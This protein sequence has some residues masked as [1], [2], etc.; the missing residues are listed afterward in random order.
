MVNP[1]KRCSVHAVDYS[2]RSRDIEIVQNQDVHQT[3]T[4]L[5][6]EMVPLEPDR[7]FRRRFRVLLTLTERLVLV[8]D[9]TD[10]AEASTEDLE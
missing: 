4:Y 1:R 2:L 10:K 8:G 6:L 9:R 5:S 7:H 3:T